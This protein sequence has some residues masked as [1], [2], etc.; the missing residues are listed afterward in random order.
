MEK[1]SFYGFGLEGNRSS[2]ISFIPSVVSAATK[3]LKRIKKLVI[4]TLKPFLLM[5][6]RCRMDRKSLWIFMAAI[7]FTFG[8]FSLARHDWD[9]KLTANGLG[10]LFRAKL[11]SDYWKILL[12]VRLCCCVAERSRKVCRQNRMTRETPFALSSSSSFLFV[13]LDSA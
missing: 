10:H 8:F 3:T 6:S 11:I 13:P 9:F 12:A 7:S 5:I 2:E 4:T 1:K